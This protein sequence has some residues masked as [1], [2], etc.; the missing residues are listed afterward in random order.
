MAAD[1]VVSLL[2]RRPH[3]AGEVI[4]MECKY[5]WSAAAPTGTAILECPG[6]R[7]TKGVWRHPAS[8][9]PGTEVWICQCGS[10]LFLLRP[11]GAWCVR[12]ATWASGWAES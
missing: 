4:C 11:E 10:D 2:T 6:C 3:M 7:C 8:P 5:T 1:N 9:A 12:C